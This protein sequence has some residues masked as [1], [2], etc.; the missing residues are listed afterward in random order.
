MKINSTL[1]RLEKGDVSLDKARPHDLA[2][3]QDL[4]FHMQAALRD[5]VFLVFSAPRYSA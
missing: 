4:V 3:K 5:L 2:S 1:T